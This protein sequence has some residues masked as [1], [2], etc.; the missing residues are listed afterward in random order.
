[1][2]SQ[3]VEYAL[4]ALVLLAHAEQ[5]P[6]TVLDLAKRAQIPAPYLAKLMQGLVRAE[7]IRSRR[8]VGGGFTLG[9]GAREIAIWDIVQAVD[10]IKRIKACPLGIAGH[11]QLCALHRRLDE[12]TA[13]VEDSLRKSSLADLLTEQPACGPLCANEPRIYPL[14][15][16][17]TS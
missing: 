3:S 8:G 1:M 13:L 10:P 16:E 7:L 6:M 11:L 5:V 2:I 15:I 9:R 12:T 14:G 17:P 4:R